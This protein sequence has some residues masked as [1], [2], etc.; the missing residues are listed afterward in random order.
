MPNL[1][2]TCSLHA[3]VGHAIGWTEAEA[4]SFSLPALRDLQLVTAG[5]CAWRAVYV[6]TGTMQRSGY[7]ERK[8][9]HLGIDP[10]CLTN[11]PVLFGSIAGH[12]FRVALPRISWC[13]VM[14]SGYHPAV[15]RLY[16]AQQWLLCGLD[17][18]YGW[19]TKK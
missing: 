3:R 11:A 2:E 7:R 15:L 4:K 16:K 10:S 14:R 12:D 5:G 9:A 17:G 6:Y 1:L 13:M 19:G 8:I 18:R